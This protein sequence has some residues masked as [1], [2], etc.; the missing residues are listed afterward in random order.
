MKDQLTK[1]GFDVGENP[2][3][4]SYFRAVLVCHKEDADIDDSMSNC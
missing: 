1:A 2:P 3:L 4:T